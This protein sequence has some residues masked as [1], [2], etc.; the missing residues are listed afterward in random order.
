VPSITVHSLSSKLRRPLAKN[1]SAS[2]ISRACAASL[3]RR[4]GQAVAGRR[5]VLVNQ[6]TRGEQKAT[7]FQADH[8]F[9]VRREQRFQ[10]FRR[11]ERFRDEDVKL[12]AQHLLHE[13]GGSR[14]VVHDACS[15][16]V[17]QS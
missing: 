3:T 9:K 13:L 7:P 10:L 2:A 16:V 8:I 15:E 17:K 11:N 1:G 12:L 5:A 6:R 14:I 4:D